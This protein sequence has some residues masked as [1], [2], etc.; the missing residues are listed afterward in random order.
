MTHGRVTFCCLFVFVI[1]DHSSRAM[2]AEEEGGGNVY[3]YLWMRM[4]HVADD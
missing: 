4:G 3:V 1:T 2:T